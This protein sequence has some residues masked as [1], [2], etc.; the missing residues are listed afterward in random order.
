MESEREASASIGF[1]CPGTYATAIARGLLAKNVDALILRSRRDTSGIEYES[2]HRG[3][4]IVYV[5]EPTQLEGVSAVVTGRTTPGIEKEKGILDCLPPHIPVISTMKGMTPDGR[6]PTQFLFAASERDIAV[7]SGPSFARD[8]VQDSRHRFSLALAGKPQARSRVQGLFDGVRIDFHHTEDVIGTELLGAYKNIAA[9]ACGVLSVMAEIC[10]R[11][12]MVQRDF[13]PLVI[14]DMRSLLTLVAS[15]EDPTRHPSGLA[16]YRITSVGGRNRRAGEFIGKILREGS[17]IGF[18]QLR[19]AIE[20]SGITSEGFHA[21]LG[22]FKFL[23]QYESHGIRLVPW[24]MESM[25][26]R[27]QCLDLLS[28]KPEGASS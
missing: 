13:E 25:R 9:L 2:T 24:L 17:A 21:I 23:S 6:T 15:S 16:D 4:A 28:L 8:I 26:T 12:Q 27:K 22:L 19:Q 11:A 10:D 18:E 14:E 7:L 5:D 20:A 3:G 1:T